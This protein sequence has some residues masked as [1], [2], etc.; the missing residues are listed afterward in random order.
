M[1][2]RLGVEF[3]KKISSEINHMWLRYAP[4]RYASLCCDPLR[5]GTV[6]CAQI[7]YGTLRYGPLAGNSGRSARRQFRS[8]PA[9]WS[10]I[11]IRFG[12][13]RSARHQF[14]IEPIIQ[15]CIA[16]DQPTHAHNS[17]LPES[18]GFNCNTMVGLRMC[19]VRTQKKHDFQDPGTGG[20]IK[21]IKRT[22]FRKSLK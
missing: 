4:V 3:Y 9:R 2:A 19:V 21:V 6:C 20:Y 16:T 13:F 7:R 22:F 18:D 10:W 14:R 5:C 12:L 1:V 8:A 17:K 11:P 15:G